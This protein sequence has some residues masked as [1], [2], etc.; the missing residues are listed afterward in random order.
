V[1]RFGR[2][3]IPSAFS[4]TVLY[5]DNSGNLITSI[6]S[7]G[8]FDSQYVNPATEAG[9]AKKASVATPAIPLAWPSGAGFTENSIYLCDTYNRRALRVDKTFKAEETCLIP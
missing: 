8:N 5:Y 2:L 6:G 1:D 4:A 9:K 7:Y 3:V